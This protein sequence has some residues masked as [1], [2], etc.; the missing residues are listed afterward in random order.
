LKELEE[1]AGSLWEAR[2]KS[3][4]DADPAKGGKGSKQLD[5]TGGRNTESGVGSRM[6]AGVGFPNTEAP[7]ELEEKG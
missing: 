4:S 5:S 1:P 3:L 2:M 7:P 6:R